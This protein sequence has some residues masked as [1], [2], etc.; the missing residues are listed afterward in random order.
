LTLRNRLI[1]SDSVRRAGAFVGDIS[2]LEFDNELF[3]EA[4]G[5]IL[6]TVL[7]ASSLLWVLSAVFELGLPK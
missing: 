4:G 5:N 2:A 3:C 1:I 6:I 7:F